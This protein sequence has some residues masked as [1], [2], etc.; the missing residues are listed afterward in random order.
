MDGFVHDSGTYRPLDRVLGSR[1]G[2][3]ALESSLGSRRLSQSAPQRCGLGSGEGAGIARALTV[4]ISSA[5]I[6]DRFGSEFVPECLQPATPENA[7]QQRTEPRLC[8]DQNRSDSSTNTRTRG[9]GRRILVLILGSLGTM[10]MAHRTGT[11]NLHSRTD[12]TWPVTVDPPDLT[13]VTRPLN[14]AMRKR[15]T[16]FWSVVSNVNIAALFAAATIAAES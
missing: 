2:N 16:S 5:V 15:L 1:L 14:C 7:S 12:R 6:P 3:R 10:A 9:A 4:A 8:F 13:V 11:L